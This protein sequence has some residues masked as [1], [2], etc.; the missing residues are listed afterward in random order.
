MVSLS[1]RLDHKHNVLVTLKS[2]Y[3]NLRPDTENAARSSSQMGP[4]HPDQ[5]R[6]VNDGGLRSHQV[7][8]QAECMRHASVLEKRCESK[9]V[10]KV[11][12]SAAYFACSLH[13][14]FA[15]P[16]REAA[17]C[18]GFSFARGGSSVRVV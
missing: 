7:S 12:R 3:G 11:E 18:Q 5:H 9:T 4:R 10:L 16:A 15:H 14:H 8:S 13:E 17:V 2:V 6:R 1:L